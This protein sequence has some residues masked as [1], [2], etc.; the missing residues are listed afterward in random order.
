MLLLSVAQKYQMNPILSHIRDTIA[1]QDPPFIRSRTAFR[2]YS[3]AKAYELR[4]EVLDA[5]R[6]TLTFPLTFEELEDELDAMP[7]IYLHE[8][9]K[10]YEKVR[11]HLQSGLTAFRKTGVSSVLTGFSCRNT[12]SYGT[13]AWLDA[14]ISSIVK[15]PVLFD[16][17]TFHMCLSRHAIAGYSGCQCTTIPIK[18][19][20]AFWIALTSVVHNCMAKAGSDLLLVGGPQANRGS[21]CLKNASPLPNHLDRPDADIVIQSCDLINFRVHKLVLIMSSSFFDVMFSLP[22]TS[23]KEVVDGLPVLHLSEDAEV[24]ECLLTMLYPIPSVVPDSY[25]KALTLLAASQKYDMV[26]IQS[27]IRAEIQIRNLSTLTGAEVFRA[28]AIS[29]RGELPS[30]RETL[31][32]LTLDFP[33]TLESLC[34]ELPSFEGWALRDLV[35]F[36]KRCRDNLISCIQSFLDYAQPPSNIWTACADTTSMRKSSSSGPPSPWLTQIFQRHL[37]ELGQAFTSPLLNS[38]SIRGEYL[39]ALHAHISSSRCTSC[40]KV[41]ALNGETFCKELE[42][43]LALAVSKESVTP[44]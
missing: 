11:T 35:R 38:S 30:E 44:E 33:M 7:C 17:T 10:Y 24:L 41:H 21:A 40:A 9:W 29:S 42:D 23:D 31:A 27:R 32:R 3:L 13:L 37:T 20:H 1:S 19:I 14:Y 6:T 28:Y 5:A 25:D 43:K 26:G 34:D 4:Q 15:S 18:T 36:R 16:L 22:Q 39:S 12:T 2:V 8:L